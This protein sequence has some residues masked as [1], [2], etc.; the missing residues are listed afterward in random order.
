M[1]PGESLTGFASTFQWPGGVSE[2]GP[3]AQNSAIT[4]AKSARGT[5]WG[6]Y[7]SPVTGF[8]VQPFPS[9]APSELCP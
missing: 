4:R 9:F 8:F 5:T 1:K 6:A 2:F 7:G 3:S